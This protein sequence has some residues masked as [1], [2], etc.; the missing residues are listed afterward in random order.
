[1]KRQF[2]YFFFLQLIEVMSITFFFLF[3]AIFI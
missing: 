2:S 3:I 1:M